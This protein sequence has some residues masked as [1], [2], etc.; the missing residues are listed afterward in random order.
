M[1]ADG[2]KNLTTFNRDAEEALIGC[3][4]LD[5]DLI[6]DLG[7]ESTDF[8]LSDCE[9][10]FTAVRQLRE[11][12]MDVDLVS[13]KDLLGSEISTE[14]LTQ[15]LTLLPSAAHAQTYAGIVKEHSTR[16][17]LQR[18]AHNVLSA[19]SNDTDS[20]AV[21][22]EVEAAL[23][24]IEVGE[25]SGMQLA[26]DVAYEALTRL[27]D[28][29]Y[30]PK[31]TPTGFTALDYQI[32]GGLRPGDLFVLAGRPSM[33]KTSFSLQM[34]VTAAKVTPALVFSLEMTAESLVLSY[35]AKM[36]GVPFRDIVMR[37]VKDKQW[38]SIN[39]HMAQLGESTL[40]IDDRSRR[41][42]LQ[43]RR[44]VRSFAKKH[45]PPSMVMIDYLQL[46]GTDKRYD[47]KDLEVGAATQ[48]MKELAK[49][50]GCPVILL[51]QLN[52]DLEKR[53]DKR[54]VMADLKES[55]SIEQDADIIAFIYRDEVYKPESDDK[56]IAEIIVAKQR[57][58]ETGIVPM[59]YDKGK[60]EYL[61]PDLRNAWEKRRRA[62]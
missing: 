18:M 27:Q 52:R 10:M 50:V 25:D 22:S 7:V 41:T 28:K 20:L 53:A 57:L 54:P 12:G 55:S 26:A 61:A 56:G 40:W 2:V 37:R 19:I 17:K 8:Y 13:L 32:N 51:S 42:P 62:G 36:A 39:T 4:I 23:S 60:F 24:Q 16:R 46:M 45:G 15:F 47:R 44:I 11:I 9:R 21:I 49:E 30:V 58:G 33:G 35:L 3:I 31:V 6:D 34:A 1:G 29:D 38:G 43:I 59:A 5:P 14:R 48:A